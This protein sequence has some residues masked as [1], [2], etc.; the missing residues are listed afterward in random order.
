MM[1]VLTEETDQGVPPIFARSVT[2]K[3]LSILTVFQLKPGIMTIRSVLH[4]TF[5]QMA[6][7][8]KVM[9]FP[10]TQPQVSGIQRVN[11]LRAVMPMLILLPLTRL[12]VR[13]PIVG[14]VMRRPTPRM[15]ATAAAAAMA[16]QVAAAN[17]PAL[18]LRMQ[19]GVM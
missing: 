7:S 17:R 13:L 1:L 16:L 19:Q 11:Q 9:L 6:L 5:T 15:L 3:L 18:P 10:I 14:P 4:V 12:Q 8:R 2:A